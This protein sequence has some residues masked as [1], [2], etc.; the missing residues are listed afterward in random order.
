M[1]DDIDRPARSRFAFGLFEYAQMPALTVVFLVF[2]LT[3]GVFVLPDDW[4][5]GSRVGA[6]LAMGMAAVLSFFANRM[7]GGRDFD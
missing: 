4:S 1:H 5:L 3:V 7:I 6:G 2:G